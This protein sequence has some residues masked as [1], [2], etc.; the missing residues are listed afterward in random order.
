ML[1]LLEFSHLMSVVCLGSV[2]MTNFICTLQPARWLTAEK[3]VDQLVT[4]VTSC[5]VYM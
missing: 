1:I 2:S 5:L 4:W 3:S